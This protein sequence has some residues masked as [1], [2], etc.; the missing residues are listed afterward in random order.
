VLQPL[1]AN[2]L[3]RQV[4]AFCVRDFTRIVPEI[5]LAQVSALPI[6]ARCGNLEKQPV[7]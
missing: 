5:E 1:L 3:E 4:R 7:D 6:R 2:A